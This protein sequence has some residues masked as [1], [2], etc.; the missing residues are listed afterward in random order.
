MLET[1]PPRLPAVV[2]LLAAGTFLMG[3][4][5]FV[6][7]GILP[8][9]AR[10][11]D[12]TVA[13]AGLTIT[14]FAIGMIVGAP[15]MALLTLRLPQR[16]I[17]AAAL[18]V[19]AAGHVVVALTDDFALLLVMRFV[20]ALATGAFWAVA[21]VV[22]ARVAGIGASSRALGVVL[23]G[24]MLANVLGVPLGA[25]IG[26]AVGWRGPFWALA[27]LALL[28]ALPVL[29][30]VPVEDPSAPVPSHRAEVRSLR[31]ARLWLALAACV[32]VNAGVMS[33]YSYVSPLLTD[34]AGLPG[35]AVP[36][37][38]L[39]FGVGALVGSVVGG[40]LGDTRPFAGPLAMMALTLVAAVG[41]LAFSTS[42]VAAV[43]SIALL[44]LVGLSSNPILVDFAVRYGREAPTLPSAMATSMFNLGTAIGSALVSI[45]LSSSVGTIGIPLV[46]TVFALAVFVPVLWLRA[47]DR[48][49]RLASAASRRLG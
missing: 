47:V 17:L 46:G 43:V 10:A 40:R 44:G 18:L 16:V 21:A 1:A 3:T 36:I 2:F 15:V 31:S 37:V 42:A 39:V 20:T 24:G 14:V 22:G 9:L 29:R 5:E 25:F 33:I 11:F 23:G 49:P 32:A 35:G 4:T 27:V 41:L 19:F 34:R 8:E 7:A 48:R 30:L 38:L 26:Q 13:H 45:S 28:L 12:T 6:V